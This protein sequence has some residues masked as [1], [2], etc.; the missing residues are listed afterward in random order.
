MDNSRYASVNGLSLYYEIRGDGQPLILLHGGLGGIHMFGPNVDAFAAGRK[1]IAVELQGH[2]RTAD[3]DRPLR[4]ESMADDI[5]ALA[6]QLGLTTVDVL[7]YS[8]GGGVALQTAIRHPALVRK[9]VVAAAPCMRKAFFP[10]VLATFDQM[11]PAMASMMKQSPLNELYP[12]VD[13]ERLLTKLGELLR[14]DY[15]WSPEVAQIRAHSML[16]FAD[17]DAVRPAHIADFY[18]LLGGGQRDAG[19]DGSARSP[20]QLA[21]LPGQ[22][23][24]SLSAAPALPAAVIPFLDAAGRIAPDG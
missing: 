8:L 15:D 21:V 18:G 12:H 5:A 4:F 20:A 3:I 11:G 24:Y 17:A 1:V 2:G 13:W 9:L 6:A 23:H 14:R 22:T 19:F 7:G 10:E 16:V